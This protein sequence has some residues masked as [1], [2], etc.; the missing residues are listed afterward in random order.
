MKL[1]FRGWLYDLVNKH[2]R[3]ADCI[4]I[5]S[6]TIECAK[7]VLPLSRRIPPYY[8]FPGPGAF[9]IFVVPFSCCYLRG[10]TS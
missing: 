8:S 2:D 1:S 5:L 3:H 4:H 6:I 7:I 10:I 9:E